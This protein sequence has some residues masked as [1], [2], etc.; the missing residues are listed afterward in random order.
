MAAQNFTPEENA[1][2]LASWNAWKELC[3]INGLGRRLKMEDGRVV[4]VGTPEDRERLRKMVRN[5]FLRVLKPYEDFLADET[6]GNCTL[7]ELDCAMEFD[8]ALSEYE[9]SEDHGF[10]RYDQHH[11]GEFGHVRKAKAWKD[12]VWQAVAQ[13]ADPPL[14]VVLGKLLGRTGV[15]RQVAE[16]WLTKNFSCRFVDD[17]ETGKKVLYFD[18]SR[19]RTFLPDAEDSG[20]AERGADDTAKGRAEGFNEFERQEHEDCEQTAV[21]KEVGLS[22]QDAGRLRDGTDACLPPDWARELEDAFASRTCCVV[23]AHINGVKIYADAEILEALGIGKS[24]A[25][26]EIKE[27]AVE[28]F[29]RLSPELQD[30]IFTDDTVLRGFEKWLEMKVRAEKAGRLILSR[31]ASRA[32]GVARK[33]D[34]K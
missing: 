27:N 9:H 2:T 1:R 20:E 30:A 4:V 33:E 10:E 5:A 34:V 21:R 7:S 24:R 32:D 22:E 29:R 17:P 16:E 18:D 28:Y 31:M 11:W 19:D 12:V 14:K 13:S 26:A 15:I 8:A 6:T 23:F 3:W 25:N